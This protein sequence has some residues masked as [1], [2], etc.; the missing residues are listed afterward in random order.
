MA[1]LL[2][3]DPPTQG[4]CVRAH[5]VLAQHDRPIDTTAASGGLLESASA[6]PAAFTHG[7]HRTGSGLTELSQG[8]TELPVRCGGTGGFAAGTVGVPRPAAAEGSG[9]H[10]MRGR[11]LHVVV[12]RY[13]RRVRRLVI[14]AAS[15]AALASCGSSAASTNATPLRIVFGAGG[16]NMV[17][18][19]VTIEPTGRV[20][21]S[22]SMTPRRRRLSHAKVVSLSRL[23]RHE[24]P[25][26]RSRQCAG[27]L[28]DIGA[29]FVRAAGRTVR[30]RG[31]CEPRFHRLWNT[32]AHAVDLRFG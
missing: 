22:G 5:R 21:A 26:L 31:G 25:A 1:A 4:F 23:V 2:D 32:L 24:L 14:F 20:H 9:R 11:F 17:P 27:T 28:P 13:P 7:L 19:Q 29:D 6:C 15:A 3:H 16:G 18:S 10:A 8:G 30:V 12:R